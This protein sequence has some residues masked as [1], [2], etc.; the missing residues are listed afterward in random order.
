MFSRTLPA[1]AWRL[2]LLLIFLLGVAFYLALGRVTKSSVT[3]ELLA[4]Q[5]II[6][7]AGAA[8]LVSFFKFFGDS[9]A[10]L[11]NLS[12]IERRD[13]M[14]TRDLDAFVEQWRESGLV[15]GVVLTD[16][17]GVAEFN[18]N[19]LETHDVGADLSD[20]DYFVWAKGETGRGLPAGRQG[21][22]FIGQPVVSRLGATKD[23]VIVPV[24]S[25][26]YQ[27]DVF[28]GVVVAAVQLQPLADRYLE[29]ME[30]SD[31]TEVYL[32]DQSGDLLY[33]NSTQEVMGSNIF[34]LLG[35]N[36]KSVL[37]SN[38]EGT[39]QNSFLDPKSGK[40]EE[41]LIAYSPIDS[42]DQRWI[43]IMATPIQEVTELA[44]P[45]YIRQI[46]IL[47]LVSLTTLLFGI[48]VAR[49]SQS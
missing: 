13:V 3:Q 35:N 2:G 32:V 28:T 39:F 41:H 43:L 10:V 9:V 46:A 16:K 44:G 40:V 22:Y 48:I 15:G 25:P 49:N 17:Y 37:S 14:T 34:G 12:S 1:R 30:V 20:R 19:I 47:M 8:N 31:R 38:K 7:R 6:A 36:L 42:G 11:S 18:S 45:I 4:R 5:Q 24:A 23:Q 26:V 21:E 33:S 27:R 29:L